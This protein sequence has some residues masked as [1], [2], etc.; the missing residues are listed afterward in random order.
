MEHPRQR[1][2]GRKAEGSKE[3]RSPGKPLDRKHQ[4]QQTRT[5]CVQCLVVFCAFLGLLT[6]VLMILPCPADPQ[7]Y[8]F[9]APPKLEG[10]LAPNTILSRAEHFVEGKVAGP[11]SLVTYKGDLYTGTADGR[12][13][14]IRGEEVTLVGRTGTPPCGTYETEPTCGRPLGMRVDSLGNLYIADAYLGLLKMN[15]STGEHKTLIPMDVEVAGHKMMFPNDLAMDQ[16][17]VIYLSDSSLTWQRRDVF[18]LVLEMK[19][20]GR[21][22]RYD[23]K[24]KQ[25]RQIMDGINFANGVELSPDQSYLVVAE[26]STARILKHHLRGDHAGRTEVL[27][28]NL[29]GLPDNIRRSSRGGYWVAL[30]AT[31]GTKGP[32]VMDAIQARAWLKRLIFKTIP[33]TLLL[34]AAPKYGLILEIDETGTIV[35]SYHDPDA[36]SIA[37]GSEIHEHDGH[38]YIGS[39][40]ARFIGKLAMEELDRL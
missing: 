33:T 29:P 9:S 25:V 24:T 11:E 17:G 30:A 18:S 2:K 14:R 22:L 3:K 10:P 36:A 13:L 20:E 12:V 31:R 19:P 8:S 4:T 26:T 35:A 40:F 23:T 28:D 34:H 1:K 38:L 32:N 16:D 5:P 21:V 27:A 15:I 7:E 37:G 6:T 39:Y